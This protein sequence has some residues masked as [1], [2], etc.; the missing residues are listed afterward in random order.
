M[1]F[2]DMLHLMAELAKA[3]PADMSTTKLRKY[4]STQL[5][6]YVEGKKVYK[7]LWQDWT[8]TTRRA[9]ASDIL[10]TTTLSDTRSAALA[11]NQCRRVNGN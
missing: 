4:I 10:V 3:A 6:E 11:P 1:Q 2:R 9:A 5:G 8:F 7:G